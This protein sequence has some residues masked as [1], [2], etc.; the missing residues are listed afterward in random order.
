MSEFYI[1]GVPYSFAEIE[2]LAQDDF[3]PVVDSALGGIGCA[4]ERCEVVTET[5]G[6]AGI[7]SGLAFLRGMVPGIPLVGA[8]LGGVH[9]GIVDR[10][11]RHPVVLSGLV[12]EPDYLLAYLQIVCQAGAVPAGRGFRCGGG[13]SD[14]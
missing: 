10:Q 3:D 12:D 6:V 8:G 13:G 11:L 2:K 1:Q 4:S 9:Q 7:D 14:C 5:V